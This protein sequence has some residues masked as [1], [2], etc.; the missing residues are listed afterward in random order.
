MARLFAIALCVWSWLTLLPSSTVEAPE[1]D[2]SPKIVG[3]P[4]EKAEEIFDRHRGELSQLPGVVDVG[5]DAYAILVVTTD[6]AV[7]PSEIEGIPVEPRLITPP[8]ESPSLSPTEEVS[9]IHEEAPGSAGQVQ[10]FGNSHWDTTLGDCASNNPVPPPPPVQ[11]LPPP[12]GV[13]VLH[14]DGT[15]E[16][17]DA[18][19]KGF[20][21]EKGTGEW[22]FCI[23]PGH[24][25]PIPP[26]MMPPIN[27]IPFEQALEIEDRHLLELLRLPGV[28]AVY[29]A[30]DSIVV[31][32]NQP[33]LVPSEVEGVPIRTNPS[34]GPAQGL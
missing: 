26:I 7:L 16:Q 5:M 14:A 8:S 21:E 2:R 32:T 1:Q 17:A 19:P 27:G 31:E 34:Q 3:M 11:Y 10:C 13:I 29:L 22:R 30:A 23:D 25:V 15:R 18:C 12:P 33:K 24:R 4:L 6:P 20:K 28:D 9:N